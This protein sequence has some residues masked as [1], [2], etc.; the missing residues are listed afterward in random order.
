LSFTDLSFVSPFLVRMINV[1][2]PKGGHEEDALSTIEKM[3][4]IVLEFFNVYLKE[5]GN[6]SSA[7]TY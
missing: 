2:V 7:G 1:S 6:F 4:G 5:Q 3:N